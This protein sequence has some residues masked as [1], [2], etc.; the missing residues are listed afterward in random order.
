VADQR[1]AIPRTVEI[2]GRPVE[3]RDMRTEDADALLS[4]VRAVPRHDLMFLPTDITGI[5]GLNG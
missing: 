4:F 5:E 3:F 1:T 2:D